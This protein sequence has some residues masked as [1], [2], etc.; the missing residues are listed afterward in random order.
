MKTENGFKILASFSGISQVG[1][2]KSLFWSFPLSLQTLHVEKR[3]CGERKNTQFTFHWHWG[4]GKGK[5][6]LSRA[7][8]RLKS[9]RRCCNAHFHAWEPCQ[10]Q[11]A[12][13]LERSFH[14][15]NKVSQNICTA[16]WNTHVVTTHS[17]ISSSDAR[18]SESS[19]GVHFKAAQFNFSVIWVIDVTCG[20]EPC[21]TSSVKASI[22][23]DWEPFR[24]ES[25]SDKIFWWSNFNPITIKGP[26]AR[27]W[28]P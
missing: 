25:F 11:F 28:V 9:P 20:Q 18:T 19:I 23:H 27:K 17:R 15:R 5:E 13:L 10:L 4:W 3:K 14:P 26:R 22:K 24:G 6:S 21:L 2:R 16:R 7:S 12:E 8:S 1:C